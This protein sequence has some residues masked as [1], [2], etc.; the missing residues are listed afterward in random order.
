M[1]E[2]QLEELELIFENNMTKTPIE[3][4]IDLGEGIGIHNLSNITKKTKIMRSIRDHVTRKMDETDSLEEKVEYLEKIQTSFLTVLNEIHNTS[5]SDQITSGTD[6]ENTKTTKLEDKQDGSSNLIKMLQNLASPS[7]NNLF[8]RPLKILGIVASPETNNKA[9]NYINL[10]AQIA[11]A[12]ANKHTDDEI[13]REIRKAIATNS[14]LKTYFDTQVEIG[15]PKMLEMLRNFYR[16]KSATELFQEL[17]NL[18]QR[19]NETATEFLLRGFEVRQ[20]LLAAAKAENESYEDS[21]VRST[22]HRAVRTGLKNGQVRAQLRPYLMP[23]VKPPT[24]D[25]VLLREL[26]LAEAESDETAAKQKVTTKRVN[27]NEAKVTDKLTTE[28]KVEESLKPL[29]EGL[30]QLQNQMK[31]I[32]DQRNNYNR[33]T[34]R[35]IYKCDGCKKNNLYCKHCFKCGEEN[36]QARNCKKN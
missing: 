34:D 35:K 13:C 20:R 18:S 10:T 14:P 30:N 24:Q 6:N 12:K 36:H 29:L 16:E 26:N 2:S 27:I 28:T 15:L 19:A 22:F 11:D 8:K 17:G 1:T 3:A 23:G 33:R 31:E 9:I 32:Q 4:L 25:D 21:L 7:D 5:T